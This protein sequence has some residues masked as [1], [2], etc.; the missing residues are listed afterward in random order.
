LISQL[1]VPL[2]SS[3]ITSSIR[4]PVST[5]AVAMMVSDPPP[6]AGATERAE[7]KKAFG[8]AIAVASRPPLRVRPVPRS[9]VLCARAR[10]VIESRTITTSRPISTSR[11]ARSSTMSATSTWRSAGMSKLEATT[12]P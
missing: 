6:C 11:R 7:P 3:K 2:N 8:F 4:D 1:P 10:R 12:S 9:A 5:S